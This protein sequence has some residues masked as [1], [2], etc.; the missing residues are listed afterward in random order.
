MNAEIGNEDDLYRRIPPYHYVKE[1]DRVSSAAFAALETSVD[2]SKR[3]TP[4]KSVANYPDNHL[5]S[6]KA[7][8]PRDKNLEVKHDPIKDN[9]AHTLIIGKKTQGIRK[10]LAKNCSFVIKRT[11]GEG[12][13]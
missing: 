7:K 6:L 11:T 1:D 10:Y 3:T 2:W 9:D 12:G 13:Q 5:A 4:A 8:V